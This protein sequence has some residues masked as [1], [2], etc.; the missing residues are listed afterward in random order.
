MNLN[1]SRTP[2][3]PFG[4]FSSLCVACGKDAGLRDWHS[5][6]FL[7]CWPCWQRVE[8]L[9]HPAPEVIAACRIYRDG[10]AESISAAAH[11]GLA[12]L[13]FLISGC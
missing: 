1:T 10:D 11:D 8:R 6:G 9:D 4:N 12:A 7:L 2:Q 13:G 5:M 3:N